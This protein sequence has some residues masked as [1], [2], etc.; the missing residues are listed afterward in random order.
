MLAVG[1]GGAS[2]NGVAAMRHGC[3]AGDEM[4]VDLVVEW[5]RHAGVLT[6]AIGPDTAC[7]S[8]R[9]PLVGKW[10]RERLG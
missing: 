8:V 7:S 10:L 6:V 1:F 5:V 3:G 2:E 4:R 9:V